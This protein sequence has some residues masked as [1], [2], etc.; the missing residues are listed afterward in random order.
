LKGYL[1]T[2]EEQRQ[3]MEDYLLY[4]GVVAVFAIATYLL[5]FD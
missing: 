5:L 2:G 4:A 1:P 3:R